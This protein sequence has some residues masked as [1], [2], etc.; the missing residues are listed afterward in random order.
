MHR[1]G[2]K[3]HKGVYIQDITRH[4]CNTLGEGAVIKHEGSLTGHGEE[5]DRTTK[6]KQETTKTRQDKDRP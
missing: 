1:E 2:T 5:Q 3:E 6:I 4:R